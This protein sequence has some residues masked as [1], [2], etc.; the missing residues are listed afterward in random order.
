MPYWLSVLPLLV[1]FALPVLF[2]YLWRNR[3]RSKSVFFFVSFLAAFG[4]T[5]LTSMLAGF[6][7]EPLL[8]AVWGVPRF[9]LLGKS[10]PSF[11]YIVGTFHVICN[12]ALMFWLM[13]VL[14]RSLSLKP[15][16]L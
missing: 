2:V 10:H 9:E 12:V 13:V 3:L 6:A 7:L 14:R 8:R 1:Q 5:F 15:D 16:A 11:P 4:V